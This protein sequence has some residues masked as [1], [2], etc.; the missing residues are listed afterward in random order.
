MND[1]K[2]DS[3]FLARNATHSVTGEP[4]QH[5]R[6]KTIRFTLFTQG[7]PNLVEFFT[8]SRILQ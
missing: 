4:K 1:N 5:R 2:V 6:P 8:L 7:I 3:R